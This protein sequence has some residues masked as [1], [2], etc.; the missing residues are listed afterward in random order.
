MIAVTVEKSYGT[1]TLRVRVRAG[2]IERA[3]RLA[4]QDARVV[5]P[6]DPEPFFAGQDAP[7]GVEVLP[8]VASEEVAA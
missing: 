6:I 7:G 5:F 8:H 2:S 1:A 4:G 3:L